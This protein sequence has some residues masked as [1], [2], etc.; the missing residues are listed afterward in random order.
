MIAGDAEGGAGIDHLHD[1]VEYLGCLGAAIYEVAE[2][3]GFAS[4]RWCNCVGLNV[5]AEFVEEREEF[6][7][8]A[9]YIADDVKGAVVVAAVGPNFFACDVYALDFV[10]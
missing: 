7:V 8:T 5:V 9:V 2:E 6:V 10:F 1:E 4:R 3:D